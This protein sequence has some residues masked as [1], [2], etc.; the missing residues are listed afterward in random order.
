MMRQWLSS[1]IAGNTPIWPFAVDTQ[2]LISTAD[3][4][5]ICALLHERICS[6]AAWAL[7]M[8]VEFREGI[9]RLAREKALHSLVRE[10]ECRRVLGALAQANLPVLLLK[11]TAL[12]YW[13]YTAPH[14]RERGDIDLFFR[15]KNDVDAVVKLL[16][17]LNFELVET[18]LPGDLISFEV[19]CKRSVDKGM[20][21][22][23][24]LHWHLSNTPMFAFR[25]SFD[26][27][28]RDSFA[29]PKLAPNAFGLAPIPAYLHACMHRIQNMTIDCENTLR[30]LYD[31]H[32]L[33]L[34][35]SVDDWN[36]LAAVAT[37]KKL[38]GVCIDGMQAAAECFGELAPLLIIEQ[39]KKAA[40]H[41]SMDVAKMH[42]W[43]YIQRMNFLAYPSLRLRLRWLRQRLLPDINYMRVYYGQDQGF[44][45]MLL[46]RLRGIVARLRR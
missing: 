28:V 36:T 11:G 44:W 35:F 8:P 42:R 10:H 43:F 16:V 40:K 27:L 18:A 26:E 39:L 3:E 29:L 6:D 46:M 38:A 13:A 19:T 33:G 12:A 23:I 34:K 15:S 21:L 37:E 4:E 22:E 45:Q 5:G 41:E 24:D 25:F 1:A 17:E 14:L 31:L 2:A 20:T 30:W 9:A 32:V 7:P